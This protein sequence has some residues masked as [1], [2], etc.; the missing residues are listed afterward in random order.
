MLTTY[1]PSFYLKVGPA[2][3]DTNF[4]CKLLQ[5]LGLT[6]KASELSNHHPLKSLVSFQKIKTKQEFEEHYLEAL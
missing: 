4:R 5:N 2:P 1:S 6:L 3:R